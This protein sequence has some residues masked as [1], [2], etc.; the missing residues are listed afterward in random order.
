MWGR[1]K[2]LLLLNEELD[3]ISVFDRLLD[4]DKNPGHTDNDSFKN[5]QTRRSEILAEIAQIKSKSW[6]ASHGALL[7]LR[8][9]RQP[10]VAP[11]FL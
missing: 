10:P 2:Q 3:I 1:Q 11:R 7:S 6:F 9:N 4:H 8:R 5:R